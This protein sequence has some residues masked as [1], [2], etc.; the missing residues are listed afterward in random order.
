MAKKGDTANKVLIFT[1]YDE[2]LYNLGFGDLNKETIEVDYSNVSN[3]GDKVKILPTVAE[4]VQIFLL[5]HPSFA[6]IARVSTNSRTRPYQI[7]ISRFYSE[8]SS[9]YR[10]PSN[11]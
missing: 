8:I 10:I 2:R 1:K 9:N 11:Q 7:A 6:V 4:C 5:I 3:N